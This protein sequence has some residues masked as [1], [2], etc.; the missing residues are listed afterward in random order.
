MR[1]F[2]N[3]LVILLFCSITQLFAKNA[4]AS[5]YLYLVNQIIPDKKDVAVFMSKDLVDK[6]K[7]KLERAAATFG[8]NITIYLIDSQRTIGRSLKKLDDNCSL[9]VYET[10][11]LE[12]KSSKMFIISK[13]KEKGVPIISASEEYAKA[14]A[15]IGIIVDDKFKISQLFVNLQNHGDLA[16][17]FTE[18]FSL[19]LGVTNLI[20]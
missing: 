19:A 16:P 2:I 4:L 6:E 9:I 12:E 18:E 7:I 17:K 20:K 10:P 14:G 3:S 8:L 5:Q 15:F 11:V 13:C 1:T